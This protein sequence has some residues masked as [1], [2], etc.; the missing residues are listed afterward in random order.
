MTGRPLRAGVSRLIGLHNRRRGIA[1]ETEEDEYHAAV[2]NHVVEVNRV[3]LPVEGHFLV[4]LCTRRKRGLVHER[5][6]SAESMSCADELRGADICD[7]QV[8]RRLIERDGV[9]SKGR[10]A[11]R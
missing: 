7:V 3:Q 8:S 11:L 5:R 1:G 9:K 2:S 10:N 4:A 6:L